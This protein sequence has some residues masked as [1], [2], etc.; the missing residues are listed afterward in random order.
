MK[1]SGE[2]DYVAYVLGTQAVR[3]SLAP[4]LVSS[5]VGRE[6]VNLGAVSDQVSKGASEEILK[7]VTRLLTSITP[8]S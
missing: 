3:S 4:A 6:I 7:G 5:I 2:S 8:L 1:P